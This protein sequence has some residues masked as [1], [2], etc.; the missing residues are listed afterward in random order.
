[1]TASSWDNTKTRSE[2]HFDPRGW[3]DRWDTVQRLGHVEPTW[4]HLVADIV[5][6]SR[7]VT[8]RTRGDPRKASRPEAELAAEEYDLERAGYGRDFQVSN[9][10][11]EIPHELQALSQSFGFADSMTRIHV[12]HPGQV[13]NLHLDKL[14]KWSPQDPSQVMR[15]MIQL[16]DWQPGHF[17]LYGNYH[18]WGWKAGDIT[19]FDWRNVPHATA[20]AGLSPRVTLQ[21]TG[22][23]TASTRQFLN[24]LA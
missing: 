17:W 9:L 13:W 18:F 2:Y 11:W 22:I 14:E 1:M 16:T 23:V 15:V 19:S 7:A 4:Q 20:N 5:E 3:D 21:V 24:S 10:N 6:Q 12:Q 8:W